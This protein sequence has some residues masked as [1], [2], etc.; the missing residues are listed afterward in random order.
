MIV[1][2]GPSILEIGDA[3]PDLIVLPEYV[4]RDEVIRAARRFPKA[5][6]VGAYEV[7][8]VMRGVLWHGGQRRVRYTKVCQDNGSF[9]PLPTRSPIYETAEVSIAVL[10]CRDIDWIPLKSRIDAELAISPT[11]VKLVCVP[12]RMTADWFSGETVLLPA[13]GVPMVVSNSIQHPDN[14][15]RSF[16]ANGS[17]QRE[18][19]QE[20][21]EAVL[22][23]ACHLWQSQHSGA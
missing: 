18:H 12:A 19:K 6:V 16:I 23:D 8:G 15:V 14:R 2:F 9:A 3:C 17:G 5:M 11:P 4:D 21:V 22:F 7:C 1:W 10:V 20:E 13:P